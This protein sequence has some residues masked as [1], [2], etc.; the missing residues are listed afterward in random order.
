MNIKSQK[1][2]AGIDII[3]ALI[4]ISIFIV[5]ITVMIVKYNSQVKEIELK[6]LAVNYAVN[7][8]ENIKNKGYIDYQDENLNGTFDEGESQGYYNLGIDNIKEL[9]VNEEILIGGVGTSFYLTTTIEDYK[10]IENSAESNLV[11]EITV[12]VSYMFHGKEN[13]ETLKTVI[14]KNA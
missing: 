7:E 13:N 11:K 8:I 14:F 4:S 2:I 1:G 9:K 6:A 5:I 3:I 10:H 12:K